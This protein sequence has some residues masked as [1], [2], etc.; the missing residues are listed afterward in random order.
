MLRKQ[1]NKSMSQL[2]LNFVTRKILRA[3]SV[4]VASLPKECYLSV[5]KLNKAIGACRFLFKAGQLSFRN[6]PLKLERVIHLISTVAYKCGIS[7]GV[8]VFNLRLS[9]NHPFQFNDFNAIILRI[10]E[11][12]AQMALLD[13]LSSLGRLRAQRLRC[14]WLSLNR[15]L[16]NVGVANSNVNEVSVPLGF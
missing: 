1:I 7:P 3:G 9:I 15:R 12:C 14:Y 6:D 10:K 13:R 16:K 2:N 11:T 5:F 8:L 4:N